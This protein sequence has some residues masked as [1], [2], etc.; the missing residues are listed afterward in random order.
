MPGAWRRWASRV[1]LYCL[2]P[3]LLILLSS[4]CATLSEGQCVAG[5]WYA[6]GKRDGALGQA[7]SR[8]FK[9]GQACAQYGMRPDERAYDAG[10]RHGLARYCTPRQGFI[11]GREGRGYR[12]V[13]TGPVEYA[14]LAAFQAGKDIHDAEEDLEWIERQIRSTES[15]LDKKDIDEKKR[16]RLRE[17]L[18]ELRDDHRRARQRLDYVMLRR[19]RVGILI[20]PRFEPQSTC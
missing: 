16:E 14:F 12:G 7:R 5:D 15:G 20:Q 6:I 19:A 4:G 1:R 8:L 18:K 9:H 2:M 11:E 10:R 17:R 13:C 3:V